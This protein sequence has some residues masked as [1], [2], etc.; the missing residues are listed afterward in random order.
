MLKFLC[1]LV[2]LMAFASASEACGGV[3]AR[4]AARVARR[5][6]SY[7]VPVCQPPAIQSF[8]RP[9]PSVLPTAT[10]KVTTTTTTVTTTVCQPRT[11]AYVAAKPVTYARYT[12]ATASYAPVAPV[13]RTL[14]FLGSVGG[15]PGGNCPIR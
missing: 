8:P 13:R 10:K 6:V 7:M 11:V 2:G 9:M 4:H 1:P 3:G 15:C 14:T 5:H 12:A